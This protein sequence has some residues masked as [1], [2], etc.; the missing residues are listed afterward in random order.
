[1]SDPYL[2]E[3]IEHRYGDTVTWWKPNR[4]GYTESISK[5]GRYSKEDAEEIC[6]NANITGV[7]NERCWPEQ[8]V[9]ADKIKNFKTITVAMYR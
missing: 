9:L 4:L 3:S 7:I 8:M 2:I 6:K 1:M 5:A